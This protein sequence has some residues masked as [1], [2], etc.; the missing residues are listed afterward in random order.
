M[1][2]SGRS[3]IL[4]LAQTN[5]TFSKKY[6]ETV[7]TAGLLDLGGG[8]YKWVRLY[9]IVKRALNVKYHKYQWISCILN[10]CN[11]NNDKRP[12]SWKVF[13]DT[14]EAHEYDRLNKGSKADWEARKQ[15]LLRSGVPVIKRKQELIEGAIANAFSLCL[16]KPTKIRSFSAQ[17]QDPSF[18]EEEKEHIKR[19][20]AQ[21][22]LIFME[23]D[24]S[25][26]HFSKIP[27]NFICEFEDA[28]GH[29][30]KLSVLDWEMSTLFRNVRK[31]GITDEKA[32]ALTLQKYNDSIKKY[33][34]H[35]ILG[36]R[37]RTHNALI[38]NPESPLNPWSI[39]SVIP[40][41]KTAGGEQGVFAGIL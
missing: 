41:P 13:D 4:I 25:E 37:H 3:R 17:Y 32:K 11:R 31:S 6:I 34:V 24:F 14:I 26:V 36:T 21:K 19:A 16:F 7:C 10:N 35:F 30:L 27:Y 8:K 18:T 9:P 20:K 38:A 22:L 39:I 5:P 1:S 40:F 12:E 33:D 2:D 23:N 15:I 28:D 29:V